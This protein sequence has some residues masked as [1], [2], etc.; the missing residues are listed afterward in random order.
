MSHLRTVNLA[1][2]ADG[3]LYEA[4]HKKLGAAIEGTMSSS[5][6]EINARGRSQSLNFGFTGG[7]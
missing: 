2:S 4:E 1:S 7:D 5:I 3:N 6:F